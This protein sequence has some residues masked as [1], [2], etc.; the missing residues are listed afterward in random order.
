MLL[1]GVAAGPGPEPGKRNV[2]LP[3]GKQCNLHS[4]TLEI[5]F[6]Y[7]ELFTLAAVI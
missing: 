5:T 4:L 7:M 3:T 6:T 2:S 1:D